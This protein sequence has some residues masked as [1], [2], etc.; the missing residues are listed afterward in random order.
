MSIA[1]G[2]KASIS[3][4]KQLGKPISQILKE[5]G[6]IVFKEGTIST[7]EPRKK[8]LVAFPGCF[9]PYHQGHKDVIKMLIDMF[10]EDRVYIL[11]SEDSIFPQ[12]PLSY[13]TRKHLIVNSSEF[14]IRATHILPRNINS[15]FNVLELAKD[16][17]ISDRMEEF[18]F[19]CVMASG[20]AD[21]I[22][23]KDK[24]TYFQPW[25]QELYTLNP[26]ELYTYTNLLPDMT[27]YGFQFIVDQID[28]EIYPQKMSIKEGMKKLLYYLTIDEL[29][30]KIEED[31]MEGLSEYDVGSIKREILG[32]DG[33]KKYLQNKIN[34]E[35]N[36]KDV[37]DNNTL[38]EK[39]DE[40]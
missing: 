1:V 22:K 28:S 35:N 32:D 37:I 17:R 6:E 11:I 38:K 24:E 12:Q 25:P 7:N 2:S 21:L 8:I 9:Q 18:V 34:S 30:K 16:L 33:A 4:H 31:D 27:K 40:T 20:D 39:L 36:I 19:I 3:T 14:N 29:R 10:G 26:K 5:F 23:V 15:G 13:N